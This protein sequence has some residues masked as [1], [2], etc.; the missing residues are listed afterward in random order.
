MIALGGGMLVAALLPRGGER[1]GTKYSGASMRRNMRKAAYEGASAVRE[2]A[3]E[4]NG[5]LDARKGAL[6]TVAA[7]RIGGFPRDLLARY[8]DEVR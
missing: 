8:R 6:M 7:T 1:D 3:R 2:K 4:T 5:S